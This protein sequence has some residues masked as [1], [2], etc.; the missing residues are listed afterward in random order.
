MYRVGR[1]FSSLWR[2]RP[3]TIKG[4]FSGTC[5]DITAS[6]AGSYTRIGKALDELAKSFGSYDLYL[7]DDGLIYGC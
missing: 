2:N 3:K 4:W 5:G 1:A 7:G 6:E